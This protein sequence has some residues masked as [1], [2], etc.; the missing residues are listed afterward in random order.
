MNSIYALID[1][2][3]DECRYIGK[4]RMGLHARLANHL[5]CK[6]AL[7]S[8]HWIHGLKGQGYAP[9]VI[10]LESGL[11][12]SEWPEAEQF[13]IAYFK[14]IGAR[15]TNYTIGGHHIRKEG[16]NL[17][18]DP[19]C[20]SMPDFDKIIN[21]LCNS[22]SAK[23]LSPQLYETYRHVV[24]T[25]SKTDDGLIYYSRANPLPCSHLL[26]TIRHNGYVCYLVT[27]SD[28]F[29][30]TMRVSTG[31]LVSTRGKVK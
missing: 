9:D 5:G 16:A 7:Y 6:K 25:A 20:Y 18:P 12:E 17:D 3:T 19:D 4:T 8:S 29:A 11:S 2:L 14:M 10:E 27:K 30:R 1:P 13:W 24:K 15:L 23:R 21:R 28:K 26:T 31:I 22:P